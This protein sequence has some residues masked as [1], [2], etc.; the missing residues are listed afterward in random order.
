MR[1][2]AA[3]AVTDTKALDVVKA[4]EARRLNLRPMRFVPQKS[5]RFPNAEIS[6][7]VTESASHPAMTGR[8][9]EI[10]CS[11]VQKGHIYSAEIT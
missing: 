8:K 6:A 4:V 9:G 1:R 5:T 3:S 7:E 10:R 2:S 11:V